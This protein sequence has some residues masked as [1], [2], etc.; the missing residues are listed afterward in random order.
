MQTPGDEAP[1]DLCDSWSELHTVSSFDSGDLAG[2]NVLPSPSDGRVDCAAGSTRPA[3]GSGEPEVL[4]R[5]LQPLSGVSLLVE[6]LIEQLCRL[7][8][9]DPVVRKKLYHVIC[10]KLRSMKLLDETYGVEEF[11]FMRTHYQRALYQLLGASRAVAVPAA[12]ALHVPSPVL[13]LLSLA[14][15]NRLNWSRYHTDY[16]QLAFINKGGFGEVYRVRNKLDGEEYAVKKIRLRYR[17]VKSFLQKLQEVRTLAR[18]EH[19]NI[20]AYKAAWLEPLD[21]SPLAECSPHGRALDTA[22]LERQESEAASE[23]DS[24]GV[25]F[26]DSGGE[27]SSSRELHVVRAESLWERRE[28]VSVSHEAWA[29]LYIQMQLCD[30][31]LQQWLAR[32]N[33]AEGTGRADAGR[34]LAVFRQ[35]VSGVQYIHAKGIVHHDIKPSNVF[36]NAD[37]TRAQVGDFGLACCFQH[38]PGRVTLVGPDG[39][40]PRGHTRELGTVPYAAPEQ[41]R[42]T[43]HPKSDVYSLGIVL[44]ELL[45]PCATAMERTKL[46]SALKTE[47]ALPAELQPRLAELILAL[48]APDVDARPTAAQLLDRLCRAAAE[49]GAAE[50]DC[51]KDALI[52]RLRHVVR[53]KDQEI[54]RLAARVQQLERQIAQSKVNGLVPS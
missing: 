43:C 8:E 53:E 35:V 9:R 20:V 40:G 3:G 4:V 13:N 38:S 31:T 17:D 22:G 5:D 12:P 15:Q 2:I 14:N 33:A 1:G 21:C 51:D 44:F 25:E 11:E 42:G 6:C 37:L 45:Q 29:V 30:D 26:Q 41:L 32:R 24:C 36:V 16:E 19:P 10:T 27:T 54:E 34:A 7:L 23:D 28:V 46:I 49:T 39:S 50:D 52:D 48:T 47:R 18:L